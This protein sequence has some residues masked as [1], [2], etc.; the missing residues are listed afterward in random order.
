M[1]LVQT[2]WKAGQ[3]CKY[4]LLRVFQKKKTEAGSTVS[5][6]DLQFPA[7]LLKKDR[8]KRNN[9]DRIL[10]GFFVCFSAVIQMKTKNSLNDKL[11]I[12]SYF[13]SACSFPHL[14]ALFQNSW[15]INMHNNTCCV[16]QLKPL[17]RIFLLSYDFFV[18]SKLGFLF[19]GFGEYVCIICKVSK[20]S[21][22]LRGCFIQDC[23]I[24]RYL[25]GTLE[26]IFN[27]Y[28]V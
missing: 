14:I 10:D 26:L 12:A 20:G 7:W 15:K 3:D 1:E 21:V 17:L 8:Y 28:F 25:W 16:P 6:F 9:C 23:C 22:F 24:G 18:V 11:I 27:V 13:C 4:L 5:I 2:V 19:T